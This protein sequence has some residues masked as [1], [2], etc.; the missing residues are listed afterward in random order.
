MTQ[1][2]VHRQ[3]LK[4]FHK[5]PTKV[6]KRVS[7]LIDEFQRDPY[8]DAVGLHPLKETMLDPKVHGV[9]NLPDGYRAIVIAP[10]KGDT[11][12][13]VHIDS[14]DRAYAWA[15]NKRFEV[16]S[17]T[18][19]F[20]VFDAEEVQTIV[21]DTLQPETSISDYP[22][23][24]LTDDELFMAGVPMPLIPAVRSIHTDAGLEALSDY[25]PA[26]CRDVLY[27]LAAGM[28][29]DEALN[30][31][32]GAAAA[33]KDVAP[34]SPGDFT[35]IQYSPNFDLILIEGQEELKKILEGP[36]EEWRIFL[37]PYQ[38][39]LVTWNTNG[40]MNITGSRWNGQNRGADASR[41]SSG[42]RIK[43]GFL[44][45]ACYNVYY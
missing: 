25:L 26:D 41:S 17:M 24:R 1:L 12:L 37:H 3:I 18:G 39:K 28:T 21:N 29:L 35:K 23:S 38:Q 6:Q 32:L 40:P 44:A 36:L 30:E 19:I 45:R 4:S 14:H 42:P 22:L 2:M 33:P 31:M 16:H 27:G 11:Y 15:R 8:S 43:R 34:A 9:R 13:L 10:E 20:Q 5:L 7:E